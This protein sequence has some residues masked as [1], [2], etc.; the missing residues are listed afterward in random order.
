MNPLPPPEILQA[1]DSINRTFAVIVFDKT[2]HILY[3]NDI[4]LTAMQYTLEEAI[5]QHHRIFC[6]PEYAESE[7]YREFWRVLGDGKPNKGT[8]VRLKKD[9][10][11]IT[12]YAEYSPIFNEQGEVVK[13]VKV[14]QNISKVVNDIHEQLGISEKLLLRLLKF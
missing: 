14:A 10:S 4:F 8:F 1:W 13:V 11:Q 9:G 7:E 6:L 5:G 12:L 3:V 2:G